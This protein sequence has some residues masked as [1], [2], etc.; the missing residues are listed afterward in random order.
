V[1]SSLSEQAVG[2]TCIFCG[3]SNA[4][5]GWRCITVSRETYPILGSQEDESQ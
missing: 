5:Y 4:V 2:H 3:M 1:A